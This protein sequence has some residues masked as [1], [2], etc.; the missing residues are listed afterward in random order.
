[1]LDDTNELLEEPDSPAVCETL[2]DEIPWRRGA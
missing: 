1:M 2:F